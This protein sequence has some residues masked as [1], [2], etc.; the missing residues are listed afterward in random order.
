[1][2][3]SAAGISLILFV[4]LLLM[5]LSHLSGLSLPDKRRYWEKV[6]QF[7]KRK[8]EDCLDP[9]QIP[10]NKWIDDLSLWPPVEFGNIYSYLIKTP[11]IYTQETMQAYKSLEAYNYY[12]R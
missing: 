5:A 2:Y 3:H 10:D 8:F 1:M 7:S 6:E 4:A 11:G 12:S 9:Y